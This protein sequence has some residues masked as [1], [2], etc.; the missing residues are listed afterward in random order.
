MKLHPAAV[1]E[2]DSYR[3]YVL[4][5]NQGP[6]APKLKVILPRLYDHAILRKPDPRASTSRLKNRFRDLRWRDDYLTNDRCF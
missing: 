4:L 3:S 2:F 6:P 5:S 1:V